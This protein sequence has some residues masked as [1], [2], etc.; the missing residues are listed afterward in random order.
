MGLMV[1]VEQ[2]EQMEKILHEKLP[3]YLSFFVSNVLSH[4]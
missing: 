1:V 3:H 4:Y 2:I